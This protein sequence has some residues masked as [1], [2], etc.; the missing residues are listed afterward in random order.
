M[1]LCSLT[2]LL[3][4]ADPQAVS[5]L[6][7]FF[8]IAL[9]AVLAYFIFVVPQR[10]KDQRF[11]KMISDLK[12]HDRVVTTGGLQGTVVSVQRD[13]AQHHKNRVTLRID[14]ASGA[15]VRVALWAIDSVISDET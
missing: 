3:A 5:P 8:P 11:Q 15:K 6:V 1:P 10:T 13:D 7:Q 4:Q 14:D 2:P 12:E 9:I